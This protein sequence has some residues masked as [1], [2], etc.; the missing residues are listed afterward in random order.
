MPI[1]IVNST[2]FEI[3]NIVGDLRTDA[4]QYHILGPLEFNLGSSLYNLSIFPI[5]N[6]LSFLNLLLDGKKVTLFLN[7]SDVILKE[8]LL[9]I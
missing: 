2:S 3:S 8:F 4:P 9:Q 7:L 5:E 6:Y 1:L